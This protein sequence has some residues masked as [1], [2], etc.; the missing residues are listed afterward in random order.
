MSDGKS[1]KRIVHILL[2]LVSIL[3][4]IT[5]LGIAYYQIISY[6]TMGFLDKTL[7]FKA[8]TYL[9]VPFFLLFVLHSLMPWILRTYYPE[10]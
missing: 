1:A 9:F 6:L 5:G 4:I 7:S 2:V 10:N 8:H 3:V